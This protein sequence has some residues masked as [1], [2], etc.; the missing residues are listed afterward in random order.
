MKGLIESMVKSFETKKL[1]PRDAYRLLTSLVI[2]RPIA[3][4]S[5]MGLDGSTNLAPFSFFNAVG[6]SPPT[7]MISIGQRRG[8]DKDTLRNIK[9]IKEFVVHIADEKLSE[10]MVQTSGDWSYGINEF[11][12]AQLEAISSDHVKP[13]RLKDSVVSMETKATQIVP[14]QGTTSTIVIGQII[15][16]HI[17]ESLL[18]ENWVVDPNLLK[19]VARLGSLEY[20]TLGKV[21]SMARPKVE[22]NKIIK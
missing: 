14:V 21:F 19:P 18:R 3:W 9:E 5:S 2:P 16:F 22:D 11:D 20:A 10:K 13:P 7:I 8:N 4:V 17:E 12:K 6:N 1:Q 15:C